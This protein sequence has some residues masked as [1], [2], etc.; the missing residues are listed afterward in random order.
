MGARQQSRP[1]RSE[2][3]EREREPGREGQEVRE[4]ERVRPAG[5]AVVLDRVRECGPGG[6]EG[7]HDEG[8]DGGDLDRCGVHAGL[9]QALVPDDELAIDPVDR[10]QRERRWDE[11]HAEHLHLAQQ[12]AVELEAE[13]LGPVDDE[14]DVGDERPGEVADDETDRAPVEDGDE[15]HH[16]RDGDEHVADARDRVLHGAFLDAEERGELLVVRLRPEP[17]CAGAHEVRV[18]AEAEPMPDR[19]GEDDAEREPERRH[20]HREP[21]RG[22]DHCQLP[23]FLLLVEVEA[24]ERARDPHLQRNRRDRGRRG[25]DLDAAVCARR[26]V[27]RVQRQQERREDA[28]DEPA[29]AVDRRVAAQPLELLSEPHCKPA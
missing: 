19:T 13:L 16:R 5:L 12:R 21:E 23:R 2:R 27:V 20:P 22:P 1:P 10:P 18:V 28:R 15:D 14:C 26:K 17:D 7:D 8:D 29:E 6:P 4:D 25:D 24:E 9:W 3:A 11:R